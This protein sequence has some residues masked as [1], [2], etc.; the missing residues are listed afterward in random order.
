MLT[1]PLSELKQKEIDFLSEMQSQSGK[2]VRCY[3]W[4]CE[5]FLQDLRDQQLLD[6]VDTLIIGGGMAYTFAKAQ[7]NEVGKSLLEEDYLDYA[8]EMVA[9]ANEK[10]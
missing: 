5:S 9:K 1:P 8:N 10:V 4:R 6:K 2:T 3:P 7:G